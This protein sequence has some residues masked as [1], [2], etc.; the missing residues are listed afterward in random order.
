M[1]NPEDPEHGSETETSKVRIP[2]PAA[3]RRCGVTPH[4]FRVWRTHGRGPRYT[5]LGG[6]RGRCVYS[7]EDIDAWL[8][9]R[10]FSSTSEELAGELD[11]ER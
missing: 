5:R 3:A 6:S 2:G 9:A 11:G 1:P 4:T 10:T 8:A 7:L